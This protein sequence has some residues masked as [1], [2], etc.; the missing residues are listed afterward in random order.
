[1]DVQMAGF[2]NADGSIARGN[3]EKF[4]VRKEGTGEYHIQFNRALPSVPI[5]VATSDGGQRG[6]DARIVSTDR[7]GF[8]VEGRTYSDHGLSDIGFGFMVV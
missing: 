1:M 3:R 5:V 8:V 2:I 4:A 7:N 6:S